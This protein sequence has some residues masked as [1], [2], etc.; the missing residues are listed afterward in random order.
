MAARWSFEALAVRQFKDNE[1]E[2]HFF[3]AN[4]DESQDIYYATF[5]I[6]D[7]LINDLK[8]CMYY[9]DSVDFRDEVG[10]RLGRL[11][12]H[13]EE[14][15]GLAQVYPGQ[16]ETNLNIKNFNTETGNKTLLYLDSLKRRFISLKKEATART[17]T[18]SQS[19]INAIGRNQLVILRENYENKRLN[20]LVLDEETIKKIFET[21]GR[22]IQKYNPGYMKSTS[23]VGRAHFFAPYK[24]LGNFEIDTYW[25]NLSILWIVS[26]IL[27]IA[28]YYNLLRKLINYFGTIRFVRSD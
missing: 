15:A 21:P 2:K 19:L 5:L 14:L 18:I 8:A 9:K 25:F 28:L 16:W 24:K 23:K 3:K 1:Y 4:M 7:K 11:N 22:F 26:I 17:N 12:Y 6:N 20:S 13:I 10:K 27:Y